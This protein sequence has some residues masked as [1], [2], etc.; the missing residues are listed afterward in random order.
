MNNWKREEKKIIFKKNLTE[1]NFYFSVKIN[2]QEIEIL[3]FTT[4]GMTTLGV[5]ELM[6][7]IEFKRDRFSVQEVKFCLKIII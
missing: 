5:D 1:K 3:N 2:Q 4:Y 7:V 6:L